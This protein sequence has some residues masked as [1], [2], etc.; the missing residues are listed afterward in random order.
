M[1]Q[2]V[3]NFVRPVEYAHV[4]QHVSKTFVR[5]TS[6][7]TSRTYHMILRSNVGAPTTLTSS[8][9]QPHTRTPC[10]PWRVPCTVVELLGSTG[11][12]CCGSTTFGEEM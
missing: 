4:H 12:L 2:Q 6:T 3:N 9:I 1:S 7:G 10:I 5:L 11:R 8:H